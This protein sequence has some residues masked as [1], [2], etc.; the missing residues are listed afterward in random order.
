MTTINSLNVACKELIYHCQRKIKIKG[1]ISY[2]LISSLHR[3]R[4]K[5][6]PMAVQKMF[7]SRKQT[8]SPLLGSGSFTHKQ[9]PLPW[10]ATFR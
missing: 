1:Q 8:F 4:E 3:G 9:L 6:R 5:G 2:D 7:I 10:F